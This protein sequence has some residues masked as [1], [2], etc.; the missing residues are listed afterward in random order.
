MKIEIGQVITQ[1]ISFLIMLWVLKR[2]AWKPLL[3]LMEERRTRIQSDFDT[4][5][6]QKR[7][8]ERLTSE[9]EEKLKNF[10][11]QTHVKI[12]EA[13]QKGQQIA[14]E[15]QQEAQQTAKAI[16]AKTKEDIQQEILHAK[17]QLKQ[18][19]VNMTILATKKIIQSKLDPE[20][21]KKQVLEFIEQANFNS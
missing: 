15:I 3:S 13:I 10:E 5:H 11:V 21:Q 4:I 8:I 18:D 6:E 17:V 19:L 1:I 12:Q 9:Y 20:E 7:E 2:Y 16:I 14:Q